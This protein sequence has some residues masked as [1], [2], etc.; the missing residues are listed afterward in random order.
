MTTACV[1]PG[2]G[3]QAVGMLKAMSEQFPLVRQTFAEASDALGYDLWALVS[4]GPSEDL[5]LT[6]RTQPAM[7]AAGIAV[8]RCY[9]A[10]GGPVD[11]AAGH[12]LGEITA[13]VAAEAIEF[14]AAIR[15]VQQR[16]RLMQSAVPA[17]QGGMAA[18]LMLADELVVQ[19]CRES[20]EDQVV[21]AVNFNCPG[22]VVIAGH[23]PA[24]ERAMAACKALG[25]KRVLRLPV[26]VPAH[27]SLL[28][29]AG[30]QFRAELASVA[31]KTPV[32]KVC[33][34]EGRWHTDADAIRDQL[35]QQLSKPVQWT[36]A[37][38]RLASLG[39]TRFIECGPGKVLT[40]LNKKIE[41]CQSGPCL[42]I[43][44]PDSLQAALATLSSP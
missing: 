21:E 25:A 3:S 6:E 20:A 31:I 11:Y 10:Q 17:P 26:S 18:I 16:G 41:A 7:L 9:R 14:P 2:Q 43:D 19:A 5:N 36:Q 22:Q 30:E 34:L 27:S 44:D 39:V 23:A 4:E 35:V 8:F 1:F 15:L 24:L 33:A 12:S 13:L 38:T 32:F 42:C 28:V 37:M 40:G 29:E